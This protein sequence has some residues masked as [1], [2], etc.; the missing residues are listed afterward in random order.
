MKKLTALISLLA[1]ALLLNAVPALSADT[2][3]GGAYAPYVP[4]GGNFGS[5]QGGE[6]HPTMVSG[7]FYSSRVPFDGAYGVKDGEWGNRTVF[8]GSYGAYGP[9]LPKGVVETSRS[10]CMVVATLCPLDIFK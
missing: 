4:Y 7:G 9:Y 5:E 6:S 3:S 10:N 2:L 1:M 8:S